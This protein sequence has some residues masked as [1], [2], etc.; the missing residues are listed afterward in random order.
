MPKVLIWLLLWY[1]F[2]V[3][4]IFGTFKVEIEKKIFISSVTTFK[5]QV[6]G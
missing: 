2:T 1:S 5:E 3:H 6:A 4:L